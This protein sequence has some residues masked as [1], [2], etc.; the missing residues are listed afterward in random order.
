M[1]EPQKINDECEKTIVA[2]KLFMW[3]MYRDQ[4]K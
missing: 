2:G 1:K 4:K 3:V